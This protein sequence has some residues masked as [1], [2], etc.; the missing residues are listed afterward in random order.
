MT[1]RS[2]E[3]LARE[4]GPSADAEHRTR[5]DLAAAHRLADRFG[6]SDI[7]WNHITARLPGPDE[8]FLI[9]RHGLRYDEVT[10]SNLVTL[11]LEGRVVDG[12]DDVNVTGFVIHG[13]IYRARSDV[14]CIMHTHTRAGL[15]ISCLENGLVPLVNDTMMFHGSV[16]YHDYEGISDDVAE[17]GRLAA[18]LGANRALVLRNLGL[19]T[20][21]ASVGEAFMLMY[22]LERACQ[23]QLDV[24]QTGQPYRVPSDE[25]AARAAEQYWD[26]APGR[27]EWPALLRLVEASDP[28]FRE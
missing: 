3:P 5:I 23:T 7:I 26:F 15:A 20:V 17:C 14:A 12:A 28:T 6:W 24:L 1:S 9:K 8:R 13:A 22:Y 4:A 10:A 19:L 11:D 18:S 25:I 16:G 2:V 21:G 27:D